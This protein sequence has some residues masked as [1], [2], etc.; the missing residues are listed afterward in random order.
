MVRNRVH[1]IS[2]NPNQGIRDSGIFLK[3]RGRG[4]Q[5]LKALH[6]STT[7]ATTMKTKIGERKSYSAGA[8]CDANIL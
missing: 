8:C 2:R 5:L 3:V 1:T 7:L 4:S 6:F